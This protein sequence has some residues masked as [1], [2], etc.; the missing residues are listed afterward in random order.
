ME[1]NVSSFIEVSLSTFMKIIGPSS[2]WQ[3][4]NL[5]LFIPLWVPPMASKVHRGDKTQIRPTGPKMT[6]N[7]KQPRNGQ[8]AYGAQFPQS[9][10][11][12]FLG[13]EFT[14]GTINLT[15]GPWKPDPL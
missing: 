6:V 14:K 2:V 3:L 12:T 7:P 11:Q 10:P 13:Q 9:D 8:K 1:S 4:E 5:F 15:N